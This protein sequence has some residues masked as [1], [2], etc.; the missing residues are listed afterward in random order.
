M[1]ALEIKEVV[2]ADILTNNG[3]LSIQ[4]Q[5]AFASDLM[6]DVLAYADNETLLVTGLNNPQVIRTAEMMDISAILF[7]RGK[8]PSKEII[9][10]ANENNMTVIAT[11]YIMFKACGLLYEYGMRGLE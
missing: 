8:K 7:V 1:N 11:D 5:H 10:L 6:S 3:D 9:Q 2:N 4:Y